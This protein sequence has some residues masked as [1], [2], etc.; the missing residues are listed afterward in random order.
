M[1]HSLSTTSANVHDVNQARQLLHGEEQEVWRDAGYIG[2]QKRQG[3]P[4]TG[5]GMDRGDAAGPAAEVGAGQPPQLW[6]K[7]QDVD[8]GQSEAPLPGREAA[9]RSCQKPAP[10]APSGY[11]ARAWTGTLNE[12]DRPTRDGPR[13]PSLAYPRGCCPRL[14]QT[15]PKAGA[16]QGHK[17]P[18]RDKLTGPESRSKPA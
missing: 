2:V 11:A 15:T 4:E 10:R 9:V 7:G 6:Q 3:T 14:V 8:M 16:R 13:P 1:A 18:K 12:W 5:F 17:T